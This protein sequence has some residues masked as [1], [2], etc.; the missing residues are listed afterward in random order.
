MTTSRKLLVLAFLVL[1][2][3]VLLFELII[4]SE[5]ESVIDFNDVTSE[6]IFERRSRMSPD[7]YSFSIVILDV[8]SLIESI[9]VGSASN[10]LAF[11][12]FFNCISLSPNFFVSVTRFRQDEGVAAVIVVALRGGKRALLV[13]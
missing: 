2:A 9:G 11:A 7:I 5:E 8:P 4:Y 3:C 13:I 10:S 6:S 12:L 1:L